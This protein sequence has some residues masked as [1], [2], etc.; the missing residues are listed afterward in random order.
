M[1]QHQ[2]RNRFNIPPLTVC[3]DLGSLSLFIFLILF[4]PLSSC[5]YSAS[6]NTHDNLDLEKPIQENLF[7]KEGLHKVEYYA[8]K[9]VTPQQVKLLKKLADL[10]KN[11]KNTQ[12]FFNEASNGEMSKFTSNIGL[13]KREYDQLID[14]FL[15]SSREKKTGTIIIARK[16]DVLFFKGEGPLIVLDSLNINLHTKT[17]SFKQNEMKIVSDSLDL[18]DLEIPQGDTLKDVEL[19]RGP[20]SLMALTGL[21]DRFELLIGKLRPSGRIYLSFFARY[22]EN[23]EHPIPEYITVIIDP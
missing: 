22:F 23:I 10:L 12:Q 1:S 6:T 3:I 16:Q 2:N 17:A 20:S 7:L 19:Y 4:F 9:E 5:N 21:S 14:I 8:S 18:E 11:N 15:Y 13:T